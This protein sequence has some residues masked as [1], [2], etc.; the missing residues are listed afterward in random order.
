M[1][2]SFTAFSQD[3]GTL[4][5]IIRDQNGDLI[6]TGVVFVTNMQNNRKKDFDLSKFET[7]P[8]INLNFGKYVL[9]VQSPGFKTYQ[10]EVEVTKE[11]RKIEIQLEIEEINVDVKVEQNEREKRIE[12]A[13]S[14]FLS[15]SEIASLPEN[16]EDIRD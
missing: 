2:L 8:L 12:E 9:E 13:F 1:L 4:S 14:G 6:T 3:S 10:E 11:N 7:S 5:I 16:G 15:E